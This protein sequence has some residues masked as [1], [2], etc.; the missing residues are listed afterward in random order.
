MSSQQI[1][2]SRQIF[3][4]G[5]HVFVNLRT[6]KEFLKTATTL[7]F[8]IGERS[9]L[10]KNNKIVRRVEIFLFSGALSCSNTIIYYS[11][12]LRNIKLMSWIM[13]TCVLP[14]KLHPFRRS[15]PRSYK[16]RTITRMFSFAF[17]HA[18]WKAISKTIFINSWTKLCSSHIYA[19]VRS[20]ALDI[21]LNLV[22]AKVMLPFSSISRQ[23]WK[24]N[25]YF[26]TQSFLKFIQPSVIFICATLL[27]C[28]LLSAECILLRNWIAVGEQASETRRFKCSRS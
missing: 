25:F 18:I 17:V 6:M 19:G 15:K 21:Y 20:S 27:F 2:N 9:R 16:Y 12:F 8:H 7:C 3:K 11:F 5:S 26:N 4:Y 28:D 23:R 14:G 22:A 24:Y 10:N 13:T 1:Y